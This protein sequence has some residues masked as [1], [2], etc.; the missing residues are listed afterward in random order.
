MSP[1]GDL[2]QKELERRNWTQRE[3]ASATSAAEEK[4]FKD[5]GYIKPGRK[6]DDAY[7][8]TQSTFAYI[9][10]G[11]TPD[12][13][14]LYAIALAFAADGSN[15]VGGWFGRLVSAMGYPME[16]QAGENERR[17]RAL[18]V[19]T[20]VSDLTL[21]ERVAALASDQQKAVAAFVEAL[22]RQ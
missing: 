1:L 19:L 12:L 18:A 9:I 17:A 20:A 7:G 2:V 14:S 16:Q 6:R 3:A 10:S 8:I 15:T 11:R 5:W 4:A 21:L 22:I 13:G